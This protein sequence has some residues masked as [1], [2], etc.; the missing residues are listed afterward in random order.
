MH[1]TYHLTYTSWYCSLYTPY[2]THSR[3]KL[4]WY[5]K[6]SHKTVG[7]V[8]SRDVN[9]CLHVFFVI[10]CRPAT[11]PHHVTSYV[12]GQ[13]HSLAIILATDTLESN[14]II[15][16][17]ELERRMNVNVAANNRIIII[18][19]ISMR[20]LPGSI[21]TIRVLYA[22]LT[23]LAYNPI[24]SWPYVHELPLTAILSSQS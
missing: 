9:H 8:E 14:C 11:W 7:R 16:D 24:Q 17:E 19:Y 5:V 3:S 10:V 12:I 2:A 20:R 1:R 6:G 18:I 4:Q 21:W 15:N 22:F 23:K 13:Q